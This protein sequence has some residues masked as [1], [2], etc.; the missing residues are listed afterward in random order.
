M[1]PDPILRGL[2]QRGVAF[3]TDES[4]PHETRPDFK[5][6]ETPFPIRCFYRVT[7]AHETRPD[8]KGIETKSHV[9]SF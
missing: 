7:V 3:G 1:K 4:H 8:F 2:K 6:I 9:L 5:G